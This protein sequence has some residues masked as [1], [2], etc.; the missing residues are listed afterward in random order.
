[1]FPALHSSTILSPTMRWMS[2]AFVSRS[3][4][5]GAMPR[6]ALRSWIVHVVMRL[7]T[8]SSPSVAWYSMV[9]RA[10]DRAAW[11]SATPA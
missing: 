6:Y 9:V 2:M 11:S 8:M 7:I 10:S 1:M 3:W 4:P 5:V